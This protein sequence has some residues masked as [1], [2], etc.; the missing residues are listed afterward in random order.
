MVIFCL[1]LNLNILAQDQVTFGHTKKTA[2]DPTVVEN[3]ADH[4]ERRMVFIIKNEPGG[5]LIGNR[6]FEKA[7]RSFGFEYLMQ[8][9]GQP[10]NRSGTNRFMHNLGAKITLV[11]RNGPFWKS[12]LNKKEKE[13][14]E[15]TGDFMGMAE[16]RPKKNPHAAD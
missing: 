4:K 14:R 1:S 13:C 2:N 12:R 3:P 11:F 8:P 9:K 15:L 10:G 5:L 6:C 7:T 16:P